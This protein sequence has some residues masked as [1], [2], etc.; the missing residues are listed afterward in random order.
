MLSLGKLVLV[1]REIIE[2]LEVVDVGIVKLV[3]MNKEK[4]FKEV[5]LLFKDKNEYKNMSLFYNFY[6]DGK[7]VERIII[8]IKGLRYE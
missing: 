8:F 5:N 1:M 3:G 2:C 6:G 7:V 4:I